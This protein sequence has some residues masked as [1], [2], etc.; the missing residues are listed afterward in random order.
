MFGWNKKDT[1]SEISSLSVKHSTIANKRSIEQLEEYYDLMRGKDTGND[2][3]K[4][5][6]V[7]LKKCSCIPKTYSKILGDDGYGWVIFR[8]YN[9][10]YMKL[11]NIDLIIAVSSNDKI[12]VERCDS[13]IFRKAEN[14]ELLITSV[15]KEFI[16][17]TPI[18]NASELREGLLVRPRIH[19]QIITSGFVNSH[20]YRDDPNILCLST[21]II[22]QNLNKIAGLQDDDIP[23]INRSD[24]DDLLL[25]ARITLNR[26][27]FEVKVLSSLMCIAS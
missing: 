16:E 9:K 15:M 20:N 25:I 21:F 23:N 4:G 27:F 11:G 1:D 7:K 3:E 13:R 22:M 8:T 26:K 18:L 10:K 24:L 12:L 19:S 2:Y 5:D 17:D 14:A 6:F